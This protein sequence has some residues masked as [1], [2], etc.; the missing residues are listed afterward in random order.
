M[1]AVDRESKFT[2]P[3][4][5]NTANGVVAWTAYLGEFYP[6]LSIG[7]KLDYFLDSDAQL[8]SGAD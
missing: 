5:D 1:W 2:T 8:P 4:L 3:T 6:M 7:A